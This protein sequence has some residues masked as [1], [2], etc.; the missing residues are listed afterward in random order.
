MI[1]AWRTRAPKRLL[2]LAIPLAILAAYAA[3][4]VFDY[5]GVHVLERQPGGVGEFGVL[6][7]IGITL[8]RAALFVLT[9]GAISF[10]SWLLPISRRAWTLG[11]VVFVALVAV[12]RVVAAIGPV[13]MRD[14]PWA[15]TLFRAAFFLAGCLALVHTA[16]SIDR[17]AREDVLLA[18]AVVPM[19][20][21]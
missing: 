4:N 16:R 8:A 15:V 21:V 3:F 7:R 9:L 17:N 5:G 6:A 10:V 2:V 19:S 12:T 20:S 14:E 11:L 13:E 18:S 1:D